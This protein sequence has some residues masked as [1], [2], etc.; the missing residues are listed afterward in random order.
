M[1]RMRY[2][3]RCLRIGP[4][5]LEALLGVLR[6]VIGGNKVVQYTGMVWMV[7]VHLFEEPGSLPLRLKAL[8]AFRNRAEDG[9]SIKQLCLIIGKLGIDR[10]HSVPVMLI[11]C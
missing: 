9:Q 4:R 8:G 3:C 11:A 7:G 5:R 6:I 1:Q 2:G 10:S